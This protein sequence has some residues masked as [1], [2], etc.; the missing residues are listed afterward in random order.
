MNSARITILCDNINGT[1]KGFRKDSGF[2][3]LI[4]TEEK[5]ILFDTGMSSQ[6]LRHNLGAAHVDA[7]SLDAV[8]LSHNHND[9]SDGLPVVL[10]HNPDVPVYIHSL[11]EQRI[12]FIG[13]HIPARNKT[14]VNTGGSQ[15]GLPPNL[16]L[17]DPLP[18]DDYGGIRE[19]AVFLRL[20][21]SLLLLTGCCHPGLNAFLD[22]RSSLGLDQNLPLHLLG[23]MHG[24]RFSDQEAA[25]LSPLV[26]SI[27]LCHCTQYGRMFQK[28][29]RDKCSTSI[30]GKTYRYT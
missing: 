15:P 1:E 5:R 18:S 10:E 7:A 29:F 11:W 20:E 9:H 17:T 13:M 26:Q 12:P 28:Q 16:Y 4:E 27:L 25:K 8:I 23:G 3:A 2:S 14:V 6:H 21:Q 19:Q 30:L 22:Q 24:F